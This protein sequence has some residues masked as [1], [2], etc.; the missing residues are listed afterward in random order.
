MSEEHRFKIGGEYIFKDY[1]ETAG[2]NSLD[3]VQP[4]LKARY[5]YRFGPY[6]YLRLW[7]S[8]S[9]R[10]YEEEPASLRDSTELSTNPDEKH[11]YRSYEG[12]IPH[13]GV[14]VFF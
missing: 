3:W 7:Y 1:D 5:R 14:A 11:R 8:I 4:A 12:I 2:L 10:K 6:H 9:E 13:M